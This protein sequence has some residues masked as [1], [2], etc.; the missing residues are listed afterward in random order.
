MLK[1]ARIILFY[2]LLLIIFL[3]EGVGIARGREIGAF[4][5]ISFPFF[6]FLFDVIDGKEIILPFWITFFYS[7]FLFFSVL[8]TLFSQDLVRS[9]FFIQMYFSVFLVFIYIINRKAFL[10]KYFLP[11]LLSLSIF[12]SIYSLFVNVAERNGW[13]FFVPATG[14]QLVFS[15][16]GSHNHL[17]DLLAVTLVILSGKF[18][19]KSSQ[20]K[21]L[22]SIIIFFPFFLFSY[23]RSAYQAFIGGIIFLFLN[24]KKNFS[25]LTNFRRMS[26]LFMIFISV[27]FFLITIEEVKNIPFLDSLHFD[28]IENTKLLPKTFFANRNLFIRDG[29]YSIAD[30]PLLGVGPGNYIYASAKYMI[31][32][33]YRTDS[34]HNILIDILS[35]NGVPAGIFFFLFFAG[36]F[37]RK[38]KDIFI[39]ASFFTLFLNFQTDYTH[40]IFSL[41]LLF[42][43]LAGFILDFRSDEKFIPLQGWKKHIPLLLSLIIFISVQ[44]ALISGNFLL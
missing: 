2:S 22:I 38:K 16:F 3:F 1:R 29:L 27:I 43:V 19:T 44:I 32:P 31:I 36:I 23:S 9:I 6:L 10:E 4:F 28:L 21:S 25:Y 30:K 11:F 20:R 26:I 24:L 41:F 12:F 14:Y 34:S 13:L 15:R 37:I 40:R 35:E 5:L 8:A 17:G 7:A 39:F 18:L 33:D 42:F